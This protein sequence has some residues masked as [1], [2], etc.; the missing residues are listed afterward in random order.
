M[1]EHV[2]RALQEAVERWARGELTLVHSNSSFN[3]SGDGAGTLSFSIQLKPA[4]PPKGGSA[5]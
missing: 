1:Q 5:S 3:L 2:L 4:P